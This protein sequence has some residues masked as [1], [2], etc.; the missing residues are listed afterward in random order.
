MKA[1]KLFWHKYNYLEYEILVSECLNDELKAKLQK[2]LHY[3][4]DQYHSLK[5]SI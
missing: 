4:F 5:E 3:H 2:K 1:I